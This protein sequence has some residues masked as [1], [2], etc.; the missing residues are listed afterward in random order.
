MGVSVCVQLV[1]S[2]RLIEGGNQRERYCERGYEYK[3]ESVCLCKRK[4]DCER[5]YEIKRER[6]FVSPVMTRP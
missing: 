5:G 1:K 6:V 4:R 3:R 2:E